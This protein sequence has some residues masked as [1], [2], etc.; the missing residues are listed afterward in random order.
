MWLDFE[1]AYYDVAVQYI[2]H[3]TM[4]TPPKNLVEE[5]KKVNTSKVRCAKERMNERW[6]VK[7]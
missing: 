6:Q 3:Y 7:S 4:G 2:S 1:L 5:R